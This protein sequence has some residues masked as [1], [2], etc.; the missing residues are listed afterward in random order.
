MVQICMYP[1]AT[2]EDEVA[3]RS[4]LIKEVTAVRVELVGGDGNLQK[5]V[6]VELVDGRTGEATHRNSRYA[7]NDAIKDAQKAKGRNEH[8]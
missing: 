8:D 3:V 6:V 2:A 7:V 4:C 1:K 5:R